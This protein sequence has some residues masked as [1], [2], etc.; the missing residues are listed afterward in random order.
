MVI[1]V[2]SVEKSLILLGF[3][4]VEGGII[5]N[6]V[7]FSVPSWR[8]KRFW[9]QRRELNVVWP[10]KHSVTLVKEHKRE[11]GKMS[12][13]SFE[14]YFLKGILKRLLHSRS[15]H[16]HKRWKKVESA[17]YFELTLQSGESLCNEEISWERCR[18]STRCPF[19]GA[20]KGSCA[21]WY[22]SRSAWHCRVSPVIKRIAQ[23]DTQLRT[24]PSHS[25]DFLRDYSRTYVSI[26]NQPFTMSWHL[27]E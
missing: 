3:C 19:K 23:H 15:A 2:L 7:C 5:I 9:L 13:S 1:K 11:K 26:A 10:V 24:S 16:L 20:L 6:I 4:Y 21:L 27:G 18:I 12:V 8:C 22:L 17:K 25:E 14:N